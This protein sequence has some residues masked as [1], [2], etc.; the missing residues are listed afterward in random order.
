MTNSTYLQ[1]LVARMG[2]QSVDVAPPFSPPEAAVPP[3]PLAF[4]PFADAEIVD[5]AITPPSTVEPPVT[6]QVFPPSSLDFG[7]D[8]EQPPT[9]VEPV[10]RVI[11]EVLEPPPIE[12]AARQIEP[13]AIHL[14][15]PDAVLDFEQRQDLP[16]AVETVQPPLVQQMSFAA[17]EPPEPESILSPAPELPKGQVTPDIQTVEWLLHEFDEF[18]EPP[19]TTAPAVPMEPPVE[20]EAPIIA[21]GLDTPAPQIT[22]GDIVVEIVTRPDRPE[23]MGST[24]P[25]RV[26]RPPEG[27]APRAGVRSKRG[28]GLGQM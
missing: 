8:S 23:W 2:A 9:T 26:S 7:E 21:P 22:I 17:F 1:R 6:D 11:H 19:E 12:A 5:E 4:D 20:P 15:A 13:P 18:T 10:E 28:F 27:S 25:T 24:P 16:L 14:P 3:T